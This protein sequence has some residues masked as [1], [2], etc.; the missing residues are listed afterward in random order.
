[1]AP[2]ADDAARRREGAAGAHSHGI[3]LEPAQIANGAVELLNEVASSKITGEEDRYSHTDLWDFEANLDG[4][5]QAFD[6]VR[7]MV[8]AKDAGARDE[9]RRRGSRRPKP[10]SR[11]TSRATDTCSTPTSRKAQTQGAGGAGRRARP[12]SLVEGRADRRA[13]A[14]VKPRP[15][16]REVLGGAGKLAA[17]GAVA[18]RRRLRARTRS[19][20]AAR[21]T[22]RRVERR[23]RRSTARIRPGIVTPAAGTAAL[24]RPST[25]STDDRA[26]LQS[27]L[28]DGG[29]TAAAAAHRGH[30]SVRSHRPTTRAA[31]TDTG[32]AIGLPAVEPHDHGR[33]RAQRVRRRARP[34]S[35]RPRAPTPGPARRDP[36]VRRRREPRSRPQRRRHLGAVLRRRRARSRSTRSTT[37]CASAA[38]RGACAGPSSASGA[39]RRPARAGHAAQP[40][41]ASRTAPTT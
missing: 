3:E 12:T 33:A 29:P 25:S 11:S 7:P 16:R 21:N 38:D 37:S 20:K 27:L 14:E 23:R 32:E 17:V 10:C 31:P 28:Q 8:A 26:A 24:R 40:A 1:M 39:R 5:K 9:D 35:P 4:A 34:G 36:A 22:R 6:A 15:S 30:R 19:S 41:W 2:V 18:C 13:E